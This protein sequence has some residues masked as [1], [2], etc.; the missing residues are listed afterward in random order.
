MTGL[1]LLAGAR[2]VRNVQRAQRAIWRHGRAP[3]E[4]PARRRLLL[5][6]LWLAYELTLIASVAIAAWLGTVAKAADKSDHW[7]VLATVGAVF[8]VSGHRFQQ[9]ALHFAAG[10]VLFQPRKDSVLLHRLQAGLPQFLL[11]GASWS[12][13]CWL[14]LH[15]DL[16][17]RPLLLAAACAVAA[18][19]PL[20]WNVGALLGRLVAPGSSVSLPQIVVVALVVRWG[21]DP[22]TWRG[23]DA[24][25]FAVRVFVLLF[26]TGCVG[27]LVVAWWLRPRLEARAIAAEFVRLPRLCVVLLLWP[28]A[29]WLV[30]PAALPAIVFAGVAALLCLPFAVPKLLAAVR[31]AESETAG[32]LFQPATEPSATASETDD[33]DDVASAARLVH[34]GRSPW[35]AAGRM[36]W[37]RSGPRWRAFASMTRLP[38]AV[39][40]LCLWTVSVLF[41]YGML[42]AALRREEMAPAMSL[43]GAG[44]CT[45][46]FFASSASALAHRWGVDWGAQAR[47]QLLAVLLVA[48][49]PLLLFGVGVATVLGW[50]ET[51]VLALAA[52]AATVL[53]R[54]GWRG[55]TRDGEMARFDA[56]R[57]FAIVAMVCV[58]LAL[59]MTW[60]TVGPALAL[61]VAAIRLRVARWNEGELVAARVAQRER[62]ERA[63]AR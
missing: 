51:R 1:G 7:W 20:A 8:V 58:S 62:D 22:A 25:D 45:Q 54:A 41:G 12:I 49:L 27:S 5:V 24:L 19:A 16:A 31:S 36:Y 11:L 3:D 35:R 39:F 55:L 42:A 38:G 30:A 47:Q 46:S 37:L 26:A 14:R 2:H 63:A 33:A 56:G 6:A 18:L 13:A 32:T 23:T 21:L 29:P 43:I 57:Q 48:G 9:G 59:P 34:R 15:G 17:A 60:W 40:V 10:D 53:L 52:V 44:L 28:S 61:G 4:R 50:N